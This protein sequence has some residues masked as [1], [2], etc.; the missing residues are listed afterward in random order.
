MGAARTDGRRGCAVKRGGTMILPARMILINPHISR[1]PGC[2]PRGGCP[3]TRL[4]LRNT[5]T[6]PD[7]LRENVPTTKPYPPNFTR[8]DSQI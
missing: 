1:N 8:E 3:H 2:P 6:L 5:L 7:G 4:S